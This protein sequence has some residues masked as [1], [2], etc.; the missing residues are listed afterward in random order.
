MKYKIGRRIFDITN[1]D[2][3][4]CNGACYMVTTQKVFKDYSYYSPTMSKTQFNR[5]L[6]DKA[7]IMF[8]EKLAYITGD[9]RPIIYKYYHFDISKLKEYEEVNNEQF[10]TD[11]RG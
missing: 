3:V 9:G 2:I 4:F 5:L 11:P 8:E 10:K 1:D 7:L 6:K